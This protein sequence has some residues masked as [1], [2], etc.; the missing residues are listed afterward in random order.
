M[1]RLSELHVLWVANTAWSAVRRGP[2]IVWFHPGWGR[3]ERA[4]AYALLLARARVLHSGVTSIGPHRAE[5]HVSHGAL[6]NGETLSRGKAKLTAL[7]CVLAQA[8]HYVERRGE[9]PV[10]LLDDLASELDRAPQQRVLERLAAGQAQG[11]VPGTASPPEPH[12]PRPAPRGF[13]VTTHQV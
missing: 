3:A 5:L 4:F 7:T 12:L 11:F 8:E 1:P 2:A 13:H 6:P 10:V 9:W